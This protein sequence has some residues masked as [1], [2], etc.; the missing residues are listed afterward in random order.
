MIFLKILFD[1]NLSMIEIENIFIKPI[2][3]K[4]VHRYLPQNREIF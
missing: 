2:L 3:L 4:G 1:K